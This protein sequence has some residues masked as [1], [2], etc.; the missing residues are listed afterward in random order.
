T[1]AYRLELP[2]KL[3]RVH[4]TFHVSNLK[5]CLS[6]EPLAIP[7]DEIHI[8]EKLHFIEEPVEIMD[9]EV[10]RLKQSRIP[11]V[12][13]RWNS[14]RGPEY[15]WEREDQMQKKLWQ[16]Q[17]SLFLLI[18]R[19]LWDPA[20]SVILFGDIPYCY[21]LLLKWLLQRRYYC[22]VILSAAP[23]GLSDKRVTTCGS[24]SLHTAIS[25]FTCTNSSEAP[26][27]SDGPP[28][29]D[30]YIATVAR[31][32]SRQSVRPLPARSLASRHDTSF[33]DHHSSSFQFSS[34]SSQFIPWDGCARSGSLDGFRL[35]LVYLDCVTLVGEHTMYGI[36]SPYPCDHL[37]PRK[38]FRDSY[39]SEASIE[40]DAEVGLTGT[41]VDMKLG[42]GDG[43]E[44]GDHVEID[45]R[46]ARDDAEELFELEVREN[47]TVRAMLDIERD[48]VSSLR[49]HMSLSQEEFRQVRR[50]R[51]DARGRLRRTMANTR[52]GMTHAAIEEMINQRVNAAL[53]AHQV[54]QNLELGNN[55]GN[56]NG[57]GNGNNNGNGNGNDNGDGNENGNGNGNNG[58]DN[59]DGNENPNVN[60]RGGRL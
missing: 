49:L 52:S 19:E 23:M 1:V 34:D 45:H 22:S 3:S 6:D 54:N 41:R 27:S 20:H 2:E 21:S 60:G 8:D 38:R 51:D 30:P 55:N 10:K 17:L 9:R 7:L 39:S 16:L 5:K 42:I 57:N 13:V 46:D 58:G 11:I 18:L 35:V 31:W 29:Q 32:R 28:S 33:S 40:E 12:K 44:V 43:D 37:P 59:G 53:E 56:N 47:S 36:I 25:P 50:D 4:S 24:W 15:T 26:V 14:R 48:R